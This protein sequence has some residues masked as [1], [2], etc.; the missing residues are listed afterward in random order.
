MNICSFMPRPDRNGDFP[1]SRDYKDIDCLAHG[2]MFNRDEKCM[3][4]SRCIIDDTGRCD[5]F[6]LRDQPK[7][8]DGD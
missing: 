3:V 5:G 8:V 1:V 4:P 6:Q 7:K 2:C